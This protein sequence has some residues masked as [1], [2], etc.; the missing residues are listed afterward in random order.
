MSKL[1][2]AAQALLKAMVNTDFT[3]R[4]GEE[5]DA[6]EAALADS[7]PTE[8]IV[9]DAILHGTGVSLGGKRI[10]QNDFYASP[11]KDEPATPTDAELLAKGWATGHYMAT[12]KRCQKMHDFT[13]KRSAVCRDCASDLV[14]KD[15]TKVQSEPTSERAELL[16]LISG[17]IGWANGMDYAALSETLHKVRD[18][19][20]ADGNALLRE[21]AFRDYLTHEFRKALEA[22]HGIKP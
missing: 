4:L 6:L 18:M 13:D 9:K 19:L 20:E 17:H 1:R 10:H 21:E 7:E 8:Q 15:K 5:T 12:C 11:V 14:A 22:A 2:E 3:C 16:H